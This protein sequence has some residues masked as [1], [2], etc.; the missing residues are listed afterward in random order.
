L[1]DG[2]YASID[3]VIKRLS[4][5][6]LRHFEVGLWEAVHT[7]KY[8]EPRTVGNLISGKTFYGPDWPRKSDAKGI[9]WLFGD[10]T[11]RQRRKYFQ[12]VYEAVVAEMK[13]RKL[14]TLPHNPDA[15]PE[16]LGSFDDSPEILEKVPLRTLEGIKLT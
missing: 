12:K 14:K 15:S 2:T 7:D 1:K 8:I 10:Y 5:K 9:R 3:S 11:K 6:E 13:K 16:E 4:K